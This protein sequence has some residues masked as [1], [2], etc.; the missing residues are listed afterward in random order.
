MVPFT[1]EVSISMKM[2]SPATSSLY[3]SILVIGFIHSLVSFPPASGASVISGVETIPSSKATLE[4]M[5]GPGRW[6]AVDFEED[7]LVCGDG[8]T[9]FSILFK[10]SA[11]SGPYSSA[12]PSASASTKWLIEFEGGRTPACWVESDSSN[13]NSN[14]CGCAVAPDRLRPSWSD[15]PA[16]SSSS[17]S[18]SSWSQDANIDFT[19]E[20]TTATSAPLGT[21]GSSP[22]PSSS[23]SSSS[24]GSSGEGQGDTDDGMF[25]VLDDIPVCHGWS[26]G[27]IQDDLQA[28]FEL[29]TN[30]QTASATVTYDLPIPLRPADSTMNGDWWQ[31]SIQD[32][33][34]YV[35][36]PDCTADSHLGF[37]MDAIEYD[38]S[39]CDGDSSNAAGTTTSTIYHRGGMNRHAVVEWIATAA[40]SASGGG[41]DALVT[42]AGGRPLDGNGQCGGSSSQQPS[43]SSIA[44]VLAT[45]QAV[46]TWGLDVE[47]LTIQDGVGL[48]RRPTQSEMQES[49][50]IEDDE[51][52][53]TKAM[54]SYNVTDRQDTPYD[55]QDVAVHLIT[56][57]VSSKTSNGSPNTVVW[58]APSNKDDRT[59][60]FDQLNS[61]NMPIHTY[62]VQPLNMEEQERS[63]PRFAFPHPSDSFS[64]FLTTQVAW[65]PEMKMMSQSAIMSYTASSSANPEDGDGDGRSRLSFLSVVLIMVGFVA[66]VYI[67]YYAMRRRRLNQNQS[68]PPSPVDLWFWCLTRYPGTFLA[69]SLLIPVILAVTVIV[70]QDGQISVNLDFDSYLEINTPLENTR[71][72]Y[73]WKQRQQWQSRDFEEDQC[74]YINTADGPNRLLSHHESQD[75]NIQVTFER[76]DI[77]KAIDWDFIL[78]QAENNATDADENQ[79]KLD[80][81]NLLYYSGYVLLENACKP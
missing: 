3:Y 81:A 22:R 44:P 17:S 4:T 26:Q 29:Q 76:L 21:T 41:I 61:Q 46:T 68:P 51:L 77:T 80:M 9:P 32:D 79:R 67:A 15:R 39:S 36:V 10:R 57:L 42:V 48:Q 19:V 54:E 58:I 40:A 75:D 16:P 59:T 74:A 43:V 8:K 62:E 6:Y 69:I 37:N 45:S 56:D 63:C 24:S 28:L 13:S 35:L 50:K 23:S 11:A 64:E 18:G 1:N 70:Q 33:F 25:M 31:G 27:L 12:S 65:N 53:A 2:K 66:I 7:G 71:R 5:T 14:K 78:Q 47:T 73:E 30:D 60:L 20:V 52:F 38:N 55:I 34:N 72:I 49:W